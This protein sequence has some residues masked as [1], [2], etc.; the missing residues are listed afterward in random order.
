MGAT[1]KLHDMFRQMGT[2][3]LTDIDLS[4]NLYQEPANQQLKIKV[5]TKGI[6]YKAWLDGEPITKEHLFKILGLDKKHK[7]RLEY[8]L[9]EFEKT[10][11]TY[12]IEFI[13]VDLT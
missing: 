4:G 13:E 2:D 12:D 1:K 5:N 6:F 3:Y 11:D 7:M 10:N 9:F 8:H